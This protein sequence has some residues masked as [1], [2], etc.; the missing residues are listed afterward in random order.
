MNQ[1]TP[2]QL[3]ALLQYASARLG[4]SAEQLASTVTK[5]GY[6]GLASSLSDADRRSL[7][8]LVGDPQ[9]AQAF[10]NSPQVQALLKRFS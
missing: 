8:R 7:E 9:K 3:S 1:P 6:E 5:G 10:L 2:E 4:V